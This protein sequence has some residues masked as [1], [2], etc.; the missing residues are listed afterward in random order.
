M[1]MNKL[2]L[3]FFS[4]VY[5]FWGFLWVGDGSSQGKTCKY[6]LILTLNVSWL[7]WPWPGHSCLDSSS[8]VLAFS[9]ELPS[10]MVALFLL[11]AIFGWVLCSSLFFLIRSIFF[12]QVFRSQLSI[13]SVSDQDAYRAGLK[14]VSQWKAYGLSGYP[15]RYLWFQ[16]KCFFSCFFWFIGTSVSF[17]VGCFE[18]SLAFLKLKQPCYPSG[19]FNTQGIE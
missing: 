11:D 13:S 14:P 4:L 16:E 10:S 3:V 7:F 12:C 8:V 15:G 2:W 17:C 9:W 18:A 19:M 5:I 6:L 1:K